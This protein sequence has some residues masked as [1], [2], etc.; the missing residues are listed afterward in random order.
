[1]SNHKK[2]ADFRADIDK[3]VKC[4]ACQAQCAVYKTIKRESTVARGKI[5]I[6]NALLDKDLPLDK[7]FVLDMSQCLLCGSCFDKCPNLVPTDQIVMAARREIA[8]RKGL[9]TF[10]KAI[11]SVIKRPKLMNT[12]AKS[13]D[14]FGGILF[15]K[16][17]DHSGLRLR[18]PL[19]F[20]TTDRSIP[21][22]TPTP[23][24]ER[25][26]QPIGGNTDKPTLSF[27]TGCMINYTYPE[28]GEA[29]V[30]VVRFMGFPLIIP[31]DQGCCGLPAL[32]AGDEKTVDQLAD[33]NVTAFSC[34]GQ[35]DVV[36]VTACASCY[37]GIGERYR[38]M[39]KDYAQMGDKVV[40]ILKFL[41]DNGLVE[42]LQQL[43]RWKETKRVTYH[44]P[45]HLRTQGI[46]TEPRA[47]LSA[48]PNVNFVEMEGADKCCGLGGTFSVYHYDT[49]R[50]IGKRKAD[51]IAASNA[52]LVASACPGCMMQLQ[53]SINHA[54]L[55]QQVCHV[56]ELVADCLPDS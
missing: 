4:G 46:T 33:A 34:N 1:M 29:L 54:K 31:Q 3:C 32:A 30:K 14:H 45:C 11:T 49:S 15:K 27:F 6:A 52:D 40:D 8:E 17:P 47:I 12:L 35:N 2:L 25:Y 10:G 21:D 41:A 37:S 51:G 22:F 18:F 48:L 55:P 24:R 7:R 19:P 38:A 9:S 36:I 43:P 50:E 56:L 23:F 28:V 39:G 26:P 20:I 16:I 5:A 42:K 53:D 44:D 13:S